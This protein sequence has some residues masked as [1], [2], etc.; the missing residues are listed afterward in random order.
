MFSCCPG[1]LFCPW[2]RGARMHAGRARRT[3]CGACWERAC[4]R[5]CGLPCSTWLR[6]CVLSLVI[7]GHSLHH[8]DALRLDLRALASSCHHRI[9][10]LFGG[11]SIRSRLSCLGVTCF[12]VQVVQLLCGMKWALHA[13][14]EL[15]RPQKPNIFATQPVA[16]LGC[17]KRCRAAPGEGPCQRLLGGTGAVGFS[18]GGFAHLAPPLQ[19]EEGHP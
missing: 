6:R 1:H 15:S 3:C 8:C 17:A 13:M 7:N 16:W 9:H 2:R 11:A 19:P 14:V 10:G 5:P 12:V 18:Q 4:A